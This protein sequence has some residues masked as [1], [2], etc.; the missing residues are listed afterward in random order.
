MVSAC[1]NE[2][3]RISYVLT[4][5]PDYFPVCVNDFTRSD[6]YT[7]RHWIDKLGF[8]YGVMI[9]KYTYGNRLGTL[10]FVWKVLEV[11]GETR[12]S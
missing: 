3:T 6:R 4:S 10:T 9:M 5:K 1:S 7:R 12:N 11:A 2:Y 8:L